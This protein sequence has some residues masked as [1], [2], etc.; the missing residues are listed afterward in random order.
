MPDGR[1]FGGDSLRGLL[2]RIE[3]GLAF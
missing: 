2:H 3:G 1:A